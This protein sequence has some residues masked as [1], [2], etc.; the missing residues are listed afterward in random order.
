MGDFAPWITSTIKGFEKDEKFQIEIIAPNF[1]HNQFCSFRNNGIGY[2][3]FPLNIPIINKSYDTIFLLN[4][5]TNF[6][7]YSRMINHIVRKVKP[8]LAHLWGVENPYYANSIFHL[9]KNIPVLITIQGFVTVES[10]K[11]DYRTLKRIQV[12]NKIMESY[13]N[14]GV[15]DDQMKAVIKKHCKLPNFYEH[16]IMPY[17]PRDVRGDGEKDFDLV[18]FARICKSKGIEDLIKAIALLKQSAF[19]I[20]LVVIGPV[21]RDY[22]HYLRLMIFELDLESNINF[23]GELSS[24]DRVHAVAR[25]AKISVLPTYN[26]TI[27]GTIIESMFMKLPCI[28]YAVG[29]IPELNKENETIR[30]VHKGD[31]VAL[32]NAIRELVENKNYAKKLA[33]S[34]SQYARERWNLHRIKNQIAEIYKILI[35]KYE[36]ARCCE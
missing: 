27:P 4:Y 26:D 6:L 13:D 9:E 30:L 32:A 18:F 33:D 25:K 36:N 2:H 29:G 17:M 23:I 15:R 5:R 28:A 24:I 8:N 11:A 1:W 12:Q 16:D 10:E 21:G 20:R 35:T 34:A 19:D 22:E 14:Y 7:L 31:I 3:L